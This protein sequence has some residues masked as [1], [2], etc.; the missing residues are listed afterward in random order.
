MY[1]MNAENVYFPSRIAISVIAL[2][3]IALHCSLAM[4]GV[5]LGITPPVKLDIDTQ[6]IS[7]GYACGVAYMSI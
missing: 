7:F 1:F 6:F 2:Y 3:Y 4:A 5:I